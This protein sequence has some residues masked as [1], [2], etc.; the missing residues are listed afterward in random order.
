MNGIKN[1][2][3]TTLMALALFTF[4]AHA[5]LKSDTL[6]PAEK[7]AK[8]SQLVVRLIEHYHYKNAEL[9]DEM[10]KEILDKYIAILDPN[11]MYF[12][13]KDILAFDAWKS[14]M[15][16]FIKEGRLK[17]AYDIFNLF[18]KRMQ[19]RIDFAV[20]QLDEEMTFGADDEFAWDR[21]KAE[22]PMSEK[23]LDALWT[24][25]VKNDY[26]SLKLVD[27]EPAK[28]KE[29]LSKR[30]KLMAKRI[31]ERKSDDVF[32]FY[33][34]A[35]VSLIEPHT[36]YMA[37]R[38]SENFEINMSLSLEGIG[39]VLGNDG[40][41]TAIDTVVKGGPAELEGTLKKGDKIV[42]VGQDAE[43]SFE[44]VVGWALEDVVQL[45]RGKKG[46]IV[47]LQVL[48]KN[49]EPGEMP[50]TISIV[51]DKVKLEQ[52]AAQYQI[53]K[54]KGEEGERKVG[55]IDLPTFYMDFEAYRDGDP[56]FRSTTKDVKDIL[57]KMKAD[58]VEGVIVDLR[59]NGGGSLTEAIQLTGLFIDH[60]PV[61]QT[62]FSDGKVDVKKDQSKQMAWDG[63]V[64]VMV[65]RF[66]AS[67]SEIFAAALQ[68]YGRAVIVG[69]PTF[70]KGTVQNVLPLKDYTYDRE[71][72]LGHMK[73]TIAQFFR[74]N[75]GSTQNRGVI[76][77]I[78]FPAAPGLDEY[79]E[80]SYDNALPWSSIQASN[81]TLF[82]DLSD[83]IVFLKKKSRARNKVNF[84]FTFLEKEIEL[85]E[86]EKDD[87]SISL[88]EAERKAKSEAS[89]ARKE[90]RK[91]KREALLKAQEGKSILNQV[92][93]LFDSN[94]T[95]KS[96]DTLAVEAEALA[97]AE[98]NADE[99]EEELFVDFRLQETARILG[100]YIDLKMKALLAKQG[101][102]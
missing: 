19:N 50:Q 42:A 85:Y 66:S 89:K 44:D 97:E 31:N 34:N 11:K 76:P 95:H 64:M 12:M 13:S 73:M 83:E 24:K 30:Y 27:K 40:E 25:K 49:E 75:G 2:A 84:E 17:P 14:K 90:A 102:K 86:A 29:I 20:K 63:P 96:K 3:I 79:G 71:I 88:S 48:G 82:D 5:L 35:Y 8:E 26:L 69:D 46:S 74:I 4:E 72:K 60:G 43:G 70:G 56:D 61:V 87:K 58:G 18:K 81:Y 36:G 16:D 38:T 101:D 67:A 78:E 41:Y 92:E 62:K 9:D 21:E 7:H 99:D 77:D 47:R 98:E 39:A 68:D 32:Q 51:R 45:I 22:W 33:M 28:I 100:D 23:D 91:A 6:A 55:V 54:V 59:N 80:S 94:D 10:S 37:P 57:A 15:D 1:A 53:L 52:Q 93:T 65:N